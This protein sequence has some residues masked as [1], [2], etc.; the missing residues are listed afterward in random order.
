M[1]A[2]R[3]CFGLAEK[4]FVDANDDLLAVVAHDWYESLPPVHTAVGD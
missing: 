1:K 3:I 2:A 4:L